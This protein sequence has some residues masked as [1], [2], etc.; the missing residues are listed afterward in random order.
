MNVDLEATFVPSPIPA[1]L[2]WLRPGAGDEIGDAIAPLFNPEQVNDAS[3]PLAW[4][5]AWVTSEPS[6]SKGLV[7][8]RVDG[9]LIPVRSGL[10][11]L[12]RLPAELGAEDCSRSFAAWSVAAKLALELVARHR[13]SP[14]AESTPHGATVRWRVAPDTE[15]LGK[16]D[17]L[18]NSL[19]PAAR[20][21]KGE[22]HQVGSSLLLRPNVALN[23]FL[24]AAADALLRRSVPA[25]TWSQSG[26]A[27]RVADALHC[28]EGSLALRSVIDDPLVED[29]RRWAL[30]VGDAERGQLRL[31]LRLELPSSV[32]DPWRLCIAA[33]SAADPTLQFDAREIWGTSQNDLIPGLTGVELREAFLRELGRA[34]RAWPGFGDALQ[35]AQPESVTLD[36]D[37]TAAFISGT[38]PLLQ[39]LNVQVQI[40]AELTPA[41]RRRL[42]FRVHARTKPRMS[43]GSA[44]FGFTSIAEAHWRAM[45]DDEDLTTDELEQLAAHKQPLIRY[46]DRWLLLDKAELDEVA[47]HV[48]LGDWTIQGG[49]A[50][51]AALGEENKLQLENED[52]LA[53]LCALLH[54]APPT[55]DEVPGFVGHMRPYQRRGTAWL[56]RL[57]KAG[58][59]GVL[60]DDMG[61]GKTVQTLAFLLRRNHGSSLSRSHLLVCPTSV[62]GTWEREAERFA[63]S[64][65]VYRHYGGDRTTLRK[66]FDAA[67]LPGTLCVTT[68]GLLR[69]DRE[70]LAG[71][72]W[73][74]VI[75][76]EAQAIKNPASQV[77]RAACSLTTNSRFALTGTP[78]E[79]RLAELWSIFRFVIPGLLGPIQRFQK[80]IATPFERFRSHV[81]LDRLHRLTKPFVLRRTKAEPGVLPDL[82]PKVIVRASCPLTREQ[83]TLYRAAVDIALEPIR[84]ADGMNRRGKVLALITALKQICNHPEQALGGDGRLAGRSGK[85]DRFGVELKEVLA[86]G[87]AALIFTQYRTMGEILVRFLAEE[88][89]LQVQFLHGGIAQIQRDVM[90]S[91]FQNADGPPVLVISLRAGGTGLTLT[92][93]SHVFHF[94]RWWNPAVEAQ[95]S[96]RAHRIGQGRTV[97]VHPMVCRGTLEEKIDLLLSEKAELAALAIRSGE[98]FLTELDTDLLEELICLNDRAG[99]AS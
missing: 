17:R 97:I 43:G 7:T 76:D 85:L 78:V 53:R 62:L 41:G 61:L 63:P 19:P 95:A 65:P 99:D 49:E 16:L 70:L 26:W 36:D 12:A 11:T 88:L 6:I 79:N 10:D 33:S 24:D 74:T 66:E 77:A 1:L 21:Y 3:L 87:E 45:L 15:D 47:R 98:T 54:S 57:S 86:A 80:E 52:P 34:V 75:L 27:K 8:Q 5:A 44:A 59:G 39:A 22:D 92:R 32:G 69:R 90:V 67:V 71:F 23:G 38:V 30:P 29:L 18:A 48:R 96:D 14:W 72:E 73:E 28:D 56:E 40:P 55:L 82:P 37:E 81:A 2:L 64:L 50:I 20:A 91:R 4:P 89:S 93:A 58:L 46:R 84:A 9:L 31:L 42:R 25:G 35:G 68:Y 83:A 60:A 13:V 51:A 94:D